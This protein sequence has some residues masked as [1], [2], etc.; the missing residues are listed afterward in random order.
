MR[1]RLEQLWIQLVDFVRAQPP[2]RRI[3]LATTGVGSLVVVLGL[4]WWVQR[5]LYRPL[6]TNLAEQD[7]SAIVEA[8][9]A[10]KVPFRLEDGGRAILVPAERLYELRL[11]LASRGL[12]EGGGVGF[13]LFDRQTLGQTDFLQRSNYQRALQ[14]ELARTISRLGGVESARVHLA[15]PERSLFVGEDRRPSASVVVKLAPGRALSA[16]QIDGIVHLVAASVEGL[17][18]DG[19]TVVDEGGR[20]LTTDRRGGETVGAWSGA[21]EMQASIERQ[22]AER[23]ESMLAAVVGRDK[24][25]A[26]VA[27]T[28]EAARVERTEETYD[29]ERTALRTQRTTREQTTGARTGGGA[30]GV[31][32]NLTNDPAAVNEPE[33]PRTERRDESQS[34]EV[35][36]VVSHTVAPAGVVKQLSV[37]VLIDGTYTGAGAARKFTPRPAEE[38]A[39]LKELVKN[40][41]GFSEARGDRIE[42]TSVPFQS[43]PAATGEG[44]LAA[45]GTWLPALLMRLLAVGLVAAGLFYVVRPLVLGLAAR[46]SEG[47]AALPEAAAAQLTQDNL[48]LTQQNPE[49]AAQLVREWLREGAPA[50]EG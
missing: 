48:A 44:V 4:A 12:P 34:Y 46:G 43:E 35:S 18:A 25:V 26:R 14:G 21:L 15:L 9:R 38:V 32:S 27:A 47:R 6:F 29:P 7:A 37:A 39:R 28:L 5:P 19:V 31:Q 36:K 40:A 1:A 16:A 10:E 22:L 17:A 8:L 30:P 23:V 42:I 24:A 50:I 13:E 45:L 20:M 33:G 11:A 41:V 49:R 2:A 3:V